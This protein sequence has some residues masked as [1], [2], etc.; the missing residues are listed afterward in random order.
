M[1]GN[2]DVVV[3]L[4]LLWTSIGI[5]VLGRCSERLVGALVTWSAPAPMGRGRLC[6]STIDARS[7]SWSSRSR[8]LNVEVD[9]LRQTPPW[10]GPARHTSRALLIYGPMTT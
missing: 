4:A 5:L 9:G 8:K 3:A 7:R 10:D 1:T 2:Y 6:G